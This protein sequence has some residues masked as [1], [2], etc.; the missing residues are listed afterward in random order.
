MNMKLKI[1]NVPG[2]SGTVSVQVDQ[3]GVPLE[4]FWRKRLKDAVTDK[5]V[6]VVTRKPKK[7]KAE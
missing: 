3:N 7:E 1:N 2:Y 6:E 5:C 4:R